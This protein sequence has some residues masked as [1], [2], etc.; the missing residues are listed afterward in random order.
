VICKT[1]IV[2]HFNKW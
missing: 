1:A 2:H